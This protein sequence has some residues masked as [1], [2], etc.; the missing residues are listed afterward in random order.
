Q[1]GADVEELPDPRLLGQVPDAAG[2]EAPRGPSDVRNAREH[3]G[4]CI[5][6]GAVYSVVVLAAEPV[7]PDPCR[8]RH[9]CIDTSSGSGI[10]SLAPGVALNWGT[11]V[12]P[13]ESLRVT[14]VANSHE[15]GPSPVSAFSSRSIRD[16]TSHS[17]RYQFLGLVTFFLIGRARPSPSQ[18]IR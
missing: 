1:P 18:H 15:G 5:A 11:V 10:G 14:W 2:Q 12:G 9:G 16:D 17:G 13:G 4:V 6:C 7:V 3:V 8:V